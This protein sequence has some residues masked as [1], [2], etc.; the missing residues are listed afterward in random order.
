MG[1]REGGKVCRSDGGEDVCM[2]VYVC[3][4]VCVCVFI[5]M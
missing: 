5:V 3:V 2:F 1:P 4:C